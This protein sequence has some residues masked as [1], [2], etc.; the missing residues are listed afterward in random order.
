[1]LSA[2]AFLAIKPA[3]AQQCMRINQSD[4]TVL[5]IV[6]ADIQKL[7]FDLATAI[8]QHPEL[9]KQLLKLK[10]FP[11]PAKEFVLLDYSLQEKGDVMIEIYKMQGLLSAALKLKENWKPFCKTKPLATSLFAGNPWSNNP[12][13]GNPI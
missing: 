5:E 2:L 9:V 7:T 8:Q 13:V 12:S 10:V 6:V 4:G 11:N 3:S 1:L